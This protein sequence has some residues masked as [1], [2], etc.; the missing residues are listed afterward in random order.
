MK[1]TYARVDLEFSDLIVRAGDVV[2]RVNARHCKEA[3]VKECYDRSQENDPGWAVIRTPDGRER[4][5][6]RSGLGRRDEE[7]S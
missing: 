3:A 7:G 4:V 2:K 6:R 1:E 5:C